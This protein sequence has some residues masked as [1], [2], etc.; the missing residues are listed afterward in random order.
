MTLFTMTSELFVVTNFFKAFNKELLRAFNTPT[1]VEI[2]ESYANILPEP[3][4]NFVYTQKS[5]FLFGHQ[6]NYQSTFVTVIDS[7]SERILKWLEK[8]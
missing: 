3:T 5:I 6:N 7:H 8:T 4:G 2:V 1:K